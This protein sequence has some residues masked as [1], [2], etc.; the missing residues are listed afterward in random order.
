MIALG[1]ALGSI[2]RW[3][4]AEDLPHRTSLFPWATLAVNVGGSFLLGMLVV[5][6]T[7]IW[8]P[9]RYLRPF[10]G[11]GVL[12]GFT[13]YSTYMLDTRRLLV[14][15]RT[16]EAG[17][18]VFGTLVAGLGAVWLAIVVTRGAVRLMR[19][20]RGGHKADG[21]ADARLVRG[22]HRPGETSRRMT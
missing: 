11:V 13:T 21:D 8:P 5:L 16:A 7:E 9:S 19:S 22:G 12:G 18:Y 2:G 17:A 1:G 15:G 10:F 20:R 4:V 3:T 14:S 6:A